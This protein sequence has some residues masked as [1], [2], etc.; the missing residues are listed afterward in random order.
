MAVEEGVVMGG[1]GAG[2]GLDGAIG[3]ED[4]S[5]EDADFGVGLEVVGGGED[6]VVEQF[7]VGIEEAEDFGLGELLDA[8]V[9]G[10]GE[11]EVSAVFDDA[12]GGEGLAN[13]LD[14][15]IEGGVV[16]DDGGGEEVGGVG[17]DGVEGGEGEVAAA[18]GDDDD[19]DGHGT[20]S[21]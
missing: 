21:R 5:A 13:C 16:D 12:D 20:S 8:A 7:G 19:A 14:G 4:A 1:K 6:A 3:V 11:A 18:V 15:T 10:G 9:D 17:L 2:A